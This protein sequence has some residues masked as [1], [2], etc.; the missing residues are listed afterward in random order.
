MEG[1]SQACTGKV[2]SLPVTISKKWKNPSSSLRRK[3]TW[4]QALP[5]FSTWV[6]ASCTDLKTGLNRQSWLLRY[7]GE[8]PS[9]CPLCLVRCPLG[10]FLNGQ[11]GLTQISEW[12]E[13][14]T[15]NP[16]CRKL[17]KKK[18]PHGLVIDL[19]WNPI[20]TD[21]MQT[22]FLN[23]FNPSSSSSSSSNSSWN[24]IHTDATET[25]FVCSCSPPRSRVASFVFCR[26]P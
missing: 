20:H 3:R 16:N 23:S 1:T 9:T 6:L 12:A 2:P 11:N 10:K 13:K 25:S 24:P 17:A 19:L 7:Y 8:C 22:S 18:L 21:T 4:V 5:W 15:Q 26:K 14:Q